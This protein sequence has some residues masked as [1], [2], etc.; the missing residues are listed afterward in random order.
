MRARPTDGAF[1]PVADVFNEV[2]EQVRSARMR[3]LLARG[4]PYAAGLVAVVAAVALAVWAWTTH[5]RAEAAKASETYAAGLDALQAGQKAQAQAS[6]SQV[7]KSAPAG[8]RALALMQEAALAL[9]ARRT[10]DA[11]ALFDQAA[12]VAPDAVIGDAA[13]LKAAYAVMDTAPFD[14]TAARLT[15]LTPSQ[16][17]Y[18]TMAK[19]ALAF[20]KL[21]AGRN[22]EARSDLTVLTLSADASEAART[23]AKAALSMIASG[24]SAAVVAAVKAQA[25]LPPLAPEAAS[26]LAN[27]QSSSDTSGAGVSGQPVGAP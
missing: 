17:P 9:D 14:V 18:A 19:E 5:E 15:P 21:A 20:A 26:P 8:F 12:K 25:G 6:F 16:R 11:V 7:A 13:R 22:S 24:S 3:S 2:D 10:S 1:A 23:R 27:A 4:W